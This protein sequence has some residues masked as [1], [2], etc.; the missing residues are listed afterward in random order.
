MGKTIKPY[1]HVL[2]TVK[3]EKAAFLIFN[4]W[5]TRDHN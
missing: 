2:G 1:N 4:K 3:L 5:G